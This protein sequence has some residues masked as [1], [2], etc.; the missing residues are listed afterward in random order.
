MLFCSENNGCCSR[1]DDDFV[2]VEGMINRTLVSGDKDKDVYDN[3][4]YLY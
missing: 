3:D 1:N 4:G 2:V